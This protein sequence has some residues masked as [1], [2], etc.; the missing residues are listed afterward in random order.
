MHTYG[1]PGPYAYIYAK[2]AHA[3]AWFAH[4]MRAR[5]GRA[6]V[7]AAPLVEAPRCQGAAPFPFNHFLPS[8]LSNDHQQCDPRPNPSNNLTL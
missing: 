2:L 1:R 8:D 7:G 6:T 5:R 3:C 4:G